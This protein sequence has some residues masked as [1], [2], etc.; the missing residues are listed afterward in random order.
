MMSTELGYPTD[1]RWERVGVSTDMMT[2]IGIDKSRPPRWQ[3]SIA[4][5]RYVP[6][7]EYQTYPGRRIVYFK[8]TCT[9]TG[10]QPQ[11]EEVRAAVDWKGLSLREV[12]DYE[13]SLSEPLPCHGAVIQVSVLPP[14]IVPLDEYPYFLDFQPKQRVLYEQVT[15]GSDRSSRSVESLNVSKGAG[16]THSLEVLDVNP[17]MSMATR[18]LL[19][20]VTGADPSQAG[21]GATRQMGTAE[22]N[23]VRTIEG[24]QESRETLSHTTQLSQMYTLFQAYHLGTNRALFFMSPR[25]H[26][27]EEASGFFQTPRRLDG[28]QEIFLVVSQDDEQDLPC[29]TAQ[30]DTSHLTRVPTLDYQR[31][32]AAEEPSASADAP[33][34]TSSSEFVEDRQGYDLRRVEVA[35]SATYT[36]P[37]GYVI[38][39][40][41]DLV[42]TA[43]PLS[44]SDVVV[45]ADQRSLTV[46]GVAVATGEFQHLTGV[47]PI[48]VTTAVMEG[49]W[50][51]IADATGANA[52]PQVRNAAP[53]SFTR[54]V[55]VSLRS[56]HPVV[57]TGEQTTLLLTSRSV[58]TCAREDA[59]V[60]GADSSVGR[61]VGWR[62]I[63]TTLDPADTPET[64]GTRARTE[65]LIADATRDMTLSPSPALEDRRLD[66]ELSLARLTAAALG[67]IHEVA[68]RS[69]PGDVLSPQRLRT[70]ARTIGKSPSEVTRGDILNSLPS[71]VE[72]I[73]ISGTD[74]LHLRLDAIAIP[75]A[76]TPPTPTPTAPK[77]AGRLPAKPRRPKRSSTR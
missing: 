10:Y 43:T 76:V 20:P 61:I 26:A 64:V 74:L 39:G 73:G 29:L 53:G 59:S 28:V 5:F 44:S 46:S 24:S 35:A 52:I 67:R 77:P 65:R 37:D 27:Q 38:A 14:K 34:P 60:K 54:T 68:L 36:A 22:A 4:V 12:Q 70:A 47:L 49:A 66:T 71:V 8:V 18:T 33:T 19:A 62:D 13:H 55:A 30:L 32:T 42:N 69:A 75:T 45:A 7:A 51:V 23:T 21:P 40:T 15:D 57:N 16:S 17:G 41:V 56:E 6:T 25:P 63:S 2:T 31:T 11:S 1:I 9:I 48:R 50:G 72:A 3:S 58:T